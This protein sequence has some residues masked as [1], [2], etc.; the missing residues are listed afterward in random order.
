MKNNPKW[1]GY[2]KNGI[3]GPYYY[4]PTMYIEKDYKK[5]AERIPNYMLRNEQYF[6]K[7]GISCS[8]VGVNF[9]A[10]YMPPGNLFGVNANFFTDDQEELYYALGLLNSKIAKYILKAVFNRT[11]NVS[12]KYI[13]RLPY[14][15]PDNEIKRNIANI[16]I[17]IVKNLKRDPNYDFSKEQKY[18]DEKFFEIYNIKGKDREAVEFFVADIYNR[19]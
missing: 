19:L 7:E 10:G 1:V 16:V 2:Y 6:F 5:Y 3:R 4:E 13:K 12:S 15:T 9:S 17:N 11:N 18:L 14:I 8:S